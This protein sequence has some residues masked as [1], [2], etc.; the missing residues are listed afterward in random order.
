MY[1]DVIFFIY[2]ELIRPIKF[3]CQTTYLTPPLVN[4]LNVYPP[5]NFQVYST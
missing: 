5:S 2:Y 4:T 3:T 1:F